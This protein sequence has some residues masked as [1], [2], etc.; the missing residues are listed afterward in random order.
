MRL[1]TRC[2]DEISGLLDFIGDDIRRSDFCAT[3]R[4]GHAD[5]P[6]E[7]VR[8][9]RDDH[10]LARKLYIHSLTFPVCLDKSEITF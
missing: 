7:A 9:A 10:F 1:T 3:R 4:E 5:R 6:S 2:A 8:R